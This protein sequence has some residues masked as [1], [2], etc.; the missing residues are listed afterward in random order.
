VAPPQCCSSRAYCLGCEGPQGDA[1]RV[2]RGCKP[3]AGGAWR[4]SALGAGVMAVAVAAAMC[5]VGDG[6][7]AVINVQGVVAGQ[8]WRW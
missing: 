6:D 8:R 2:V 5:G 1:Q 4:G 7:A 3:A